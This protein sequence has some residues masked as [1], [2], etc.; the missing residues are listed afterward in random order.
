MFRLP[1]PD[2]LS[3]SGSL[4]AAFGWA[5]T[6]IVSRTV[7]Q[8]GTELDTSRGV[9]A[10]EP[11]AL[12]ATVNSRNGFDPVDSAALFSYHAALD[13]GVVADERG[14][15]IFNSHWL[16][17]ADW[18]KVPTIGWDDIEAN[19]SVLEAFSPSAVRN[20]ELQRL[21]A[22]WREPS[23][24]LRPVD[25]ALV[26]RLDRWRDEALKYSNSTLRID[27]LL[28]TFYA[29]LFVL[30]TVEDRSLDV[31]LPAISS[32]LTNDGTIDRAEWTG[33]RLL[34]KERIGSDL[35]DIDVAA[36]IPDHVLSGVI[37]D[38]YF[39]KGVPGKKTK[40]DFSWIDA[41]VLGLAYEK[42]LA[43][44]LH[45]TSPPAQIDL[46]LPAERGVERRT[47]RKAAGAYY[48]PKYIT[49]Y[50]STRCVDEFFAGNP[51]AIPSIIDFACG[52]GSFL[53]AA[54]NKVLGHLKAKD[55]TQPWA[56]III[57]GGYIAGV[58]VDEKAV[59]AARL[60][61]WQ[62][63]LEEPGALPLPNLAEVVVI[64]DGLDQSTWGHL[65][66]SYDVVLGNPPFL[67]TSMVPQRGQLEANFSS[68][69]GRYDFSSLF[70]EQGLRVLNERGLL[71]LVVPNR[72][73]RSRS[74]GHIRSLV[75]QQSNL[76]SIVD[77]GATRPFDAD[78]YI[79][80]IVLKAKT[81]MEPVAEKVRVIE[82]STLDADFL[83][84]LLL[85]AEG[86]TRNS[87]I[88]R[89]F[90][91][92]HPSGHGP[93]T[94]LSPSEE[95]AR[96]QIEEVAVPLDTI[97]GI[98]QG[99]RTGA[100][101]LF[102]F[103]FESSDGRLSKVVNGLGEAAI[104]ESDLLEP[105]V[106]GSRV[107]RYEE[108]RP[109]TFLL[110][111]YRNNVPLSE[112]ELQNLYP[113]AWTYFLRNRELLSARG[114]LKRTNGKFY[115]LIWP[116]DEA[117]LRSPK[118]MIRDLAPQTAFAV[119]LK[120][121]VFLVSGTAVVPQSP[122]I[123]LALMAYLN[124]GV[125]DA[126]VKQTTPQFRGNF[127]KFEP[128]HIQSIP[129]LDRFIQDDTFQGQLAD[130]AMK[131]VHLGPNNSETRILE[132]GIDAVIRQAIE[133]RGVQLPN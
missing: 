103:D 78:A 86:G 117:W 13:W 38:L 100:N 95:F 111:P 23:D 125:I 74:A 62:R 34:A 110:Y 68:A 64:G 82:I 43:T 15:S 131:I 126:L 56:K 16:Q 47:V 124:S 36:N 14:L 107:G 79:G 22:K 119:D 7:A 5:E 46:F 80:C 39:P 42:Y 129:V 89:T 63:I 61:L 113:H 92:R 75:T 67:A 6:D 127:Q 72:M 77:F 105:S 33:I 90:F 116:R 25:D 18:Y 12:F 120:G 48:T 70:V 69:K 112:G 93:W 104:I 52:S 50:L 51:D 81:V 60:H 85:D 102:F 9:I 17:E 40:Y 99:I 101:D 109:N 37:N 58:D 123:L 88:L 10:G 1:T 2:D 44:V 83:T 114:S 122:E 118:L 29:Q 53:V 106:Y 49:N 11:A 31:G 32:A 115:E 35:F 66:K 57:E 59:T 21:A 54:V 97:A 84:A 108:I 87:G 133:E 4:A 98:P 28:Q 71:G 121:E 128:Q 94:L 27:E 73:F 8:G 91:A 65:N 132:Q 3:S 76:I 24:F 20:R 30:R 45:P 19:R 96:I 55:P 26:A 130:L 41:D